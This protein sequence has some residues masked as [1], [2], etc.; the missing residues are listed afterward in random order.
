M[1]V[2]RRVALNVSLVLLLTSLAIGDEKQPLTFHPTIMGE[3]EDSAATKAGFRTSYFRSTHL[4]FHK[5]DASDGEQA[6]IHNGDFV[7]A[8][9]ARRYFDWNLENRTAQV[10]RQGDKPGPDGKTVGRRAEFLAKSETKE[11]IWGVMW[12]NG[13]QFH[14]IT[15]PT[16]ECARALEKLCRN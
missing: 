6:E 4:G 12:T 9:E 2:K 13:D 11:K 14:L 3:M 1:G 5:Y 15:A 10:L 8:D 7:N 16:L